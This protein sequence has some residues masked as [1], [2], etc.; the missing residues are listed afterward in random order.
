MRI[1]II[2]LISY[3]FN[4]LIGQMGRVFA[5]GPGDQGSIS[6]RVIPKTLKWYLIPTCLPLSIISYVEK[7]VLPGSNENCRELR[8]R[9]QLRLCCT[10]SRYNQSSQKYIT[11]MEK[12]I[13]L[14]ANEWPKFQEHLKKKT[15]LNRILPSTSSTIGWE[16]GD[17]QCCS[18][19]KNTPSIYHSN[20]NYS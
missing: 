20:T 1:F 11:L 12:L 18:P 15:T 16:W 4:R 10:E 8:G 14:E 2:I 19:N 5:N 17:I 3:V 6:G 9:K 13:Q 7:C